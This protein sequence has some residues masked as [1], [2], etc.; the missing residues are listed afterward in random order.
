MFPEEFETLTVEHC[1]KFRHC[2]RNVFSAIQDICFSYRDEPDR[3]NSKWLSFGAMIDQSM[4]SLLFIDKFADRRNPIEGFKEHVAEIQEYVNSISQT[5]LGEC[6]NLIKTAPEIGI[7]IMSL[8]L[9]QEHKKKWEDVEKALKKNKPKIEKG[10][11]DKANNGLIRAL[12]IVTINESIKGLNEV[13]NSIPKIMTEDERKIYVLQREVESLR[14]Q[15]KVKD[16][17]IKQLQADKSKLQ[18][19]LDAEI[20]SHKDD[21]RKADVNLFKQTQKE[22]QLQQT[23]SELVEKTKAYEASINDLEAQKEKYIL[24]SGQDEELFQK[25][26][27]IIG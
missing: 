27:S 10:R 17:Q 9:G 26:L 21:L 7:D 4:K 2:L 12:A 13:Y 5:I 23:N 24:K 14:R 6:V 15:V 16:T 19:K 18:S 20:K 11:Y 8:T 1:N 3:D 22:E 25:I